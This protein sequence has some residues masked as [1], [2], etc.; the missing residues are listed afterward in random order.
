M[1]FRVESFPNFIFDPLII[2]SYLLDI[3]GL[4]LGFGVFL[5]LGFMTQSFLRVQLVAPS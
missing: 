1:Y 2:R 5:I 3:L 4:V